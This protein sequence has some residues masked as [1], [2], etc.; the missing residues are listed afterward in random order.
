MGFVA[1]MAPVG[2]PGAS[3]IDIP[4]GS[5]A[6]SSLLVRENIWPK[7]FFFRSS[8][9]L[10][11][12]GRVSFEEWDRNFNRLM[13]VMGKTLDEELP[14]R[15]RNTAFYTRFKKEHPDQM[16]LLHFNGNARDPRWEGQ[17]FFPGHW[18]YYNGARIL[19]AVSAD[20][21]ES[22]IQVSD[23]S[24]FETGGGRFNN[25]NDD[26]GLCLLDRKGR[27]DWSNSEQVQLLS[28]DRKNRTIRVR[29]GCYGTSARSFPAGEAFAAAHCAEGPWGKDS[30]L[31]WFYNYST[32][33]PK[34]EKGRSCSEI[35]VEHLGGLFGKGGPLAA[36]DGLEFDVLFNT[37]NVHS[38]RRGADCDADGRVDGGVVDGV[39]V[40]GN[41]VVEYCRLL[42]ARLGEDKIILADGAFKENN[43]QRAFGILNG[44]ESEGWPFALDK[45]IHDWSGGLNRHFF[46][47]QNARPPVFNYIAHKYVNPGVKTGPEKQPDVPFHIHRLAFAAAVFTDSAIAYAYAPP[48]DETTLLPIW[49]EFIMGTEKRVGWLGRPLGPA[50]RLALQEPDRLQG[51][52][53]PVS[54]KLL[55][56]LESKEAEIELVNGAVKCT[57]TNPKAAQFR[58]LLKN[59]PCDGPDLFVSVTAHGEAMKDYPPE[60]ARLMFVGLASTDNNPERSDS[61]PPPDAAQRGKK[62]IP[63]DQFMTWLNAKDFPSGF[64]FNDVKSRSVDLE[65]TF[66]SSEPVWITAVTVHAFPDVMSREFEHGLVV[67][68][69][70]PRSHTLDMSQLFPGKHF[71]R[72][73]ATAQQD[74]QANN[75]KSIGASLELGPRE[76]LFLAKD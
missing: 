15:L 75:G 50:V 76:G 48:R 35:Q 66:E 9:A 25:S 34:D 68:N 57:G 59:V 74:T 43:A 13:G 4:S 24:L 6:P 70:S 56:R 73:K 65:M 39:N 16:V 27:P 63:P 12:S 23:A 1:A 33:C 21:Q 52:G 8:E 54:E 49:D 17:R 32:T 37:P 22:T 67:A 45:E 60:M 28:V 64:Y 18:L 53:H 10:A 69:P 55:R 61:T 62:E 11:A 31:L 36:F 7:A 71:H 20:E 19:S 42:R 51:E 58:V 46:W 14:G 3:P 5:N 29:R 30:N 2:S 26:I 44:I 72:I 41:G 40:Y 38:N 47:N